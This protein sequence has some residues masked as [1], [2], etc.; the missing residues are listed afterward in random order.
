M[1]IYLVTGIAGFIGSALANKL[2]NLGNTVYGI[3]NLSTG[4]IS[5][6]PNK[7]IFIQDDL[8]NC[9]ALKY[10]KNKKIEIIFH[11]AAQSGGMTS[12]DSPSTDLNSNTLSTIYLLDFAKENLIKKFIYASSMAI[13]GDQNLNPVNELGKINPKTFYG[14]SKFSSELYLEAYNKFYGL[15]TI[16]LRLN[17][18]YGPGQD[19]S[20]LRQGMVS[21]FI[22]QAITH[23]KIVVRGAEDR[24]RDFVFVDDV[25]DAFIRSADYSSKYFEVFNVS[26]N[27]KTTVRELV[28]HITKLIPNNVLV[29]YQKNNPTSGD[30][31]GIYCDYD[32][33]NKEM[34]WEPKTQ[35]LSGLKTTI[36]WA[37]NNYL[38]D[39]R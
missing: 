3:D 32:K 39:L 30:Q 35:L 27:K 12:F 19:L 26:T 25:V 17:N 36:H 13:Y 23:N 16:S 34:N 4:S 10:L 7:A 11:L 37:L 21:I 33:L 8:S 24:F 38:G 28:N 29:E 15:K 18:V 14:I 9:D 22:S 6:V 1:G 31:F 2:I 5:N 20:N